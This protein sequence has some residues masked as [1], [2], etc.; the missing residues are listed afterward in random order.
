MNLLVFV[1]FFLALATPI[2]P[3][4]IGDEQEGGHG[5]FQ[6][7]TFTPS[8]DFLQALLC[9]ASAAAVKRQCISFCW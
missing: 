8:N 5:F 2:N 6:K 7:L 9:L 1:S 4:V 3:I